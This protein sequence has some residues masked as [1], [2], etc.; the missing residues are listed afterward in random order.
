MRLSFHGAAQNVTGSCHLLQAGGLRILID[1][2]MFQ[3]ARHAD[4]ENAG[5]FGFDPA[6][7]DFLLL[8][9]AHLDHCGRIP[10]LVKRGFTGEIIT[11]A[12]TRDLAKLI[13]MDSAHIQEEDAARATRRRRRGGANEIRPL[14]DQIDV[15]TALDN[16]GRNARYDNDIPLNDAVT[17]RFINAGHILGS[18]S[19]IVE[20]VE[21]GV[22][23]RIV[24]SGDLGSPGHAVLANATPPPECDYVVMETTYGDRMHRDLAA[25]VTEFIDAIAA[26][27]A[28]GGNVVIPTFAMERTQE[29]LF[30]LK[31]AIKRK[32]LSASL[33]VF[34]DSPMAVSATEI[35]RRHADG[36]SDEVRD[37]MLAGKR[38]FH[39]PGV[40]FTREAA[41]S[42]AINR[43]RGGAVIMAGSG[44]CTGGRV[45]HHL[46]HNIWRTECSVIFV[47]FAAKGTLARQIVD[48][49]KH[50]R[51]FGE[52]IQVKAEIHTING[53]S[54]HADQRELFYWVSKT[55]K[56]KK[57]F[58]VHGDY[59]KGMTTMQ[60]ELEKK[61]LRVECPTLHAAVDLA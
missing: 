47:G 61:G 14:Y 58:L 27:H 38:P 33:L 52:D 23:R 48:G 56:P 31:E 51:I 60:K 1:C 22:A 32:E 40:R 30:H 18:A 25:S 53:F 2:G 42:M 13:M 24:F 41:D 45:R 43:I 15:L 35:F 11:T 59:D 21:D 17:V 4:E 29:I 50:I 26:T 55:G 5:P 28:R 6:E 54:A 49:A 7:V 10:L 19:V 8:T 34:L 46:K 36:F 16:F 20:A 44:M 3:G 37:A 39:P 9:H 12:A 57:I